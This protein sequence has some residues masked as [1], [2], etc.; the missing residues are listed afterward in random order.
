M[1]L[2][3]AVQEAFNKGGTGGRQPALPND[4][5][6]RVVIQPSKKDIGYIEREPF[7]SKV[8]SQNHRI[9]ALRMRLV[10]PEGAANANRNFFANIPTVFEIWSDRA[11]SLTPSY[12]SIGLVK[13]LGY[14]LEDVEED[15]LQKITDRE[16]LGKSL[17]LVLGTE[18]DPKFDGNDPNELAKSHQ[19]PLYAKRNTVKFINAASGPAPA[20]VPAGGQAGGFTG[21]FPSAP[22]RAAAPA[23]PT[24]GAGMPRDPWLEAAAMGNGAQTV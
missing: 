2:S 10:I 8:E 20:P 15:T 18:D 1:A 22:P 7:S 6:V 13:A 24:E 3:P 11:G 14:S 9:E 4:T 23:A 12:Q 19:N 16:L 5:K 21:G 17:E